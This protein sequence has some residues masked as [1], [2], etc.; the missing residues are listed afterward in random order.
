[1]ADNANSTISWTLKIDTKSG[2]AEL[3][4][5]QQAADNTAKA[6]K[7]AVQWSSRG[8]DDGVGG[9]LRVRAG[10]GKAVNA[11]WAKFEQKQAKESGPNFV[12]RWTEAT[13]SFNKSINKAA[14]GLVMFTAALSDVTNLAFEFAKTPGED[15]HKLEM[16]QNAVA[17]GMQRLASGDV[18]GAVIAAGMSLATSWIRLSKEIEAA[19]RS[20]ANSRWN[21][22]KDLGR[23]IAAIGEEFA[24]KNAGGREERIGIMSDQMWQM[25]HGAGAQSLDNLRAKIAQLKASG[26]VNSD[27]YKQANA[28]FDSRKAE[29]FQLRLKRIQ[30]SINP[31]SGYM[32]K[33]DYGD[34]MSQ[35]GLGF[36]GNVKIEDTNERIYG[37]M[38]KTYDALEAIRKASQ[39][40]VLKLDAVERKLGLGAGEDY[41]GIPI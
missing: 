1:M 41:L 38:K 31:F 26:D 3:Q 15:N 23:R 8:G 35:K 5:L 24:L 19:E 32:Q 36:G 17:A 6:A 22:Y 7:E 37:L 27:E 4:Q 18:I 21:E 10:I 16:A 39:D 11:E 25:A 2:Q 34:A 13:N 29:Y 28:D 9:P 14:G 12:D 30:E 20:F 40:N 33:G